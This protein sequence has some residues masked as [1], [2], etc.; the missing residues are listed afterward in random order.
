[1]GINPISDNAHDHDDNNQEMQERGTMRM[2][3][4]VGG[5]QTRSSAHT[6]STIDNMDLDQVVEDDNI[7]V[8][9]KAVRHVDFR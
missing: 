3:P 4:S 8:E 7:A 2:I 1:M 5:L 9:S 6:S